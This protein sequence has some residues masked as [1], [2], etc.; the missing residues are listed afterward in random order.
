M[1][2]LKSLWNKFELQFESSGKARQ[3]N[4]SEKFKSFKTFL[5]DNL[6][7]PEE[8]R[9]IAADYIKKE[10]GV[11]ED[12]FIAWWNTEV[13]DS[14]ETKIV[15]KDVE[16]IYKPSKVEFQQ[17][18]PAMVSGK[19]SD[20]QLLKDFE[21]Y[22]INPDSFNKFTQLWGVNPKE[23][24]VLEWMAQNPEEGPQAQ[25]YLNLMTGEQILRPAYM[26]DGTPII[27][28]GKQAM[29]PFAGHFGGTKVEDVIDSYATTEEIRQFQ[30]FLTSSNIVPDN[31]FAESQGEPS[32]KLRASIK[33]VMNWLDKNR[34]IVPG[35]DTYDTIM[36][37]DSV[38]FSES[39]SLY[40]DFNYHRNLF[41][42][43]LEEM[44]KEA[45]ITEQI[46][47]AEV[48]KE[49]A[50]QFIPPSKNALED[51]VDS[52]FESKLG[53]SAT[54]EELDEWS[55]KFADSYSIA[56]GQARAKA[57]QYE[58]YNFMVS[59]PEYLEM[60]S[61]REQLAK[62]YGVN[63]FIDLSAF[64]TDRPE[65]IMAQQVEDEFGKQISAVE[66]G[67]KVRTMQNDMITY[68]FGR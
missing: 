13:A 40:G 36:E 6:L 59:Q 51:M 30:N 18:V 43:A 34:H 19:V 3:E 65:E 60:D 33:Y 62:D 41:R 5:K 11:A 20:P 8:D 53:R 39:Q 21:T 64:S 14:E 44:A 16:S 68:M 35:T 38:Y 28:N 22:G 23:D 58:D 46:D 57:K 10:L 54:E 49:L 66:Q 55:T 42:Y 9:E 27:I 52:Y 24:I 12:E 47:E 56:F 15:K 32:E 63:K 2:K 61:Q 25:A 31:Y 4:L 45:E 1:D 37:Q 29:M 17:Q 7:G 67:R 26:D 50:K 48:A